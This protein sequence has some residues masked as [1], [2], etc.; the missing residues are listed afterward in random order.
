MLLT[1]RFVRPLQATL[2][3]LAGTVLPV[4]VQ[5]QN[6]TTPES[7]FPR[8]AQLE[9]TVGF[10]KDVFYTYSQN[11]IVLH[12]SEYP[13]KVLRVLDLR[14]AAAVM[15]DIQFDHYRRDAEKTARAQ[16]DALLKSVHD[17]RHRPEQM[18]TE[19][20][21]IFT[22][23][24]DVRADDRFAIARNTL[25]TQRGIRERTQ[26]ALE[27]SQRYL[28]YME[29]I[30]A[31]YGLP[32][33]LTRLPIVES[34][35]NVDAYSR[36]HAAGVWQ[37]IPTSA[38]HYMRLNEVVDD[39]RDPWTSTDGAARHLRDD[40]ALLQDWPL[41][42]T[43]YNHGRYGIQRGIAAIN[44]RTLMDLINRGNH[45][46]WGFAGKNYY[47]EF[48][49]AVD[50]ERQWRQQQAADSALPPLKFEVVETR[51][52]LPYTTI[53]RL[54]GGDETLFR[55][56][57]PAYLPEVI[58]GR[59][60]V[61]P[62]HMIRV[63]AG[64]A[65]NFQVAYN[66]LGSNERFSRQRQFYTLHTVRK[67]E[68][69]GLIAKRNG[70]TIA[71]L[72]HSNGIKGSVVRIGQVLKI[73]PRGVTVTPAVQVARNAPAKPAFRQHRVQRGQTLSSIATRYDVSLTEL[74]TAN[75][76]GHG[77]LIKVGQTLRVP[78]RN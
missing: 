58:N 61:P 54:S 28:P 65:R 64:H 36:S 67:G 9:P 15:S 27:T 41:A 12:A 11:Q 21:R 44:G 31:S 24:S 63:P 37:F 66:Q 32:K 40:Y 39:R 16:M 29:Q 38:K 46:R 73:P 42:V 60:Y 57:N 52:Y 59:L 75:G 14:G 2:L 13:A 33:T 10:W 49:A 22:L 43:A 17:K 51:D 69:L 5:A 68:S 72:Q 1:L 45:P 18:T 19:E 56:L 78:A 8:F 35:F 47:A 4:N 71:A 77:N 50:I 20:R 70:T 53:Q 23:F 62:G 76:L 6:S 3:A 7:Q 30:F 74:R 26:V 48:L 25:R 55:K 34:S